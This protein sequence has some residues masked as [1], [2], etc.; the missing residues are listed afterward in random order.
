[1]LFVD[2]IDFLAAANNIH[3]ILNTSFPVMLNFAQCRHLITGA[4][5]TGKIVT[6][7][8]LAEG[9]ARAEV[10]VFQ[11]DLKGGSTGLAKNGAPSKKT[12]GVSLHQT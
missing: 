6:L 2:Q 9:F 4:S 11:L 8:V 12:A 7:Q 5:A 3:T 10:L 1:M